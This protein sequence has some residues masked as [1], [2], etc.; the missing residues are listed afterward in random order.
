[1]GNGAVKIKLVAGEIKGAFTSP[2]LNAFYERMFETAKARAKSAPEDI[3][4]GIQ[5]IVFGMFLLEAHCN[6]SYR[7]FLS[8]V[9]PNGELADAIWNATKR[10][11]IQEKV[12]VATAVNPICQTDIDVQ[13]KRLKLLLDL[14]NR[15]AH[16]KETDT[17][18]DAPIEFI[19]KPEN[20]SQ[21]PEPELMGHLTGQKLSDYIS[22]I[23]HL[24]AWFDEVFGIKRTAVELSAGPK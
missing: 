9:I 4:N 11:A 13:G 8:T 16:F 6:D 3:E 24:L 18:W 5:I 17:V 23:G 15:L 22:D 14:R 20:W 2:G 10:A 1:M 7:V 19:S 21:A 12:N